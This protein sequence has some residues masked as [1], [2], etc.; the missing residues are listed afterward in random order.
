MYKEYQD[1]YDF[2]ASI[3]AVNTH[4]HHY[5]D[6]KFQGFDLSRIL[7][8]SYVAWCGQKFDRGK[9][10]RNR[11]LQKV[12]YKHYF[13]ALQK[14][15][16]EIYDF[17]EEL[18]C[19]NWDRY[20]T[21]VAQKYLDPDW[22]LG[23][24]KRYGNYEKI[25]LDAYW[26]PGSDN[27]H[28]DTFASTFRV[29]PLFFGYDRNALDHDGNNACVLYGK[30]SSNIDEYLEFIYE[31]IKSKI[32][33]GSIC[34]KN[35]IA[36]DRD[37]AYRTVKKEDA[38]KVF[39]KKNYTAKDIAD[40][41]DYLFDAICKIAAELNVTIQCHTGMGCLN[42]TRAINMLELIRANPATKFSLMHASFPWCGDIL[43]YLDM[44]TN[45]YADV[46]WLPLL[47]P[48]AAEYVINQLIEVGTS[49][50]IV[51][52]CDTW[53][54]EESYGARLAM[55]EV[56]ARVLGSKIQKGHF[57]KTD[58]LFMA[59]NIMHDNAKELFNI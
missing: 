34:L 57:G 41:Q 22:H 54:S 18:T 14:S 42:N 10:S 8:N 59:Q 13:R 37:V 39:Q 46:A 7:E 38:D 27:G 6:E 1:I 47:S 28:P 56:L 16:M 50:R 11:Y 4:S 19:D 33:S 55:N 30:E 51:W 53:T 9:E 58:A 44:F 12:R 26:Q 2:I 48:T 49:E 43:A 5:E 15:F 24:L 35:A 45:V 25:I 31:L 36:Y 29:D 20:D 3:K 21:I 32:V 52:G 17:K 40:F 23:I